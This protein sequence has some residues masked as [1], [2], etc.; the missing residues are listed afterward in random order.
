M[1]SSQ[2]TDGMSVLI[3]HKWKIVVAVSLF[4]VAALFINIIFPLLDGI[5]MGVVLA[6]VARPLKNIFDRHVPK[7]SPYLATT[8]I[9]LPIFLITGLGVIEIFNTLLWA[10]NNQ[11]YVVGVL[12][13]SLERLNLPQFA[14]G[15]VIDIISNFSSYL[16]PILRG[17]PV[18][19]IAK[20]AAIFIINIL[21]AVVLCFYLLVDGGRLVDKINDIIP[22]EIKDFSGKF[23]QHF[24]CILSALFIGNI[25][26]AIAVGILSLIVFWAFGFA[27]VL[28]LSALMLIAA[29]VPFLAGWMVIA[30][31]VI[32]RYFEQGG[33]SALI[34]LAV[35][36][37]VLII[38]PEILIRPY[39]IQSRSKI[40]PMLII[41]AF[42]GGGL[43]GGIAGFFIAPILLGAIV[44]AYRASAEIRKEDLTKVDL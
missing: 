23:M 22:D 43:V 40:H 18:G 26:S 15:R 38:P 16:L 27:D 8:A 2:L 34:F 3:K 19:A 29:I 32:Y 9:V 25:Y 28:A 35:S 33:Q 10:I 5:I 21:I 39:I 14:R 37:L 36:L 6:Y 17:L 7:L 4:L 31:L 24:D 30:P 12:L 20:A 13:S 42:L 11:D 44:A 41:I 1:P